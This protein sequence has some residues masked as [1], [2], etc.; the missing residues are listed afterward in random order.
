MPSDKLHIEY[1]LAGLIIL[2]NVILHIMFMSNMLF[3]IL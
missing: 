1:Y 3:H 2:Y